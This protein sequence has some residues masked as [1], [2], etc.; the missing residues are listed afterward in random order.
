MN[1]KE[2]MRISELARITGVSTQTIHYYLR[3]GLLLPPTKTAPNMA[4][5]GSEHVEDIKLIKQLQEKRYLP[6][7]VIKLVL[8]AKREGKDVS[9]LRDMRLIMEEIFLPLGP[10]ERL[11]PV[12][13]ME[14]VVITG[15][16]AATLE[17]LEEPGLLT[18][19][20][21]PEGKRYNGLDVRIARAVKELLDLGLEPSDLG[22]YR[23]YLE[24][25][26]AEAMVIHDKVFHGSGDK[27][28]IPRMEIKGILD[29]LKTSLV[30]KVYRQ[31]A[32]D[33]Q[34]KEDTDG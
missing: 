28:R 16:S 34:H 1:K 27:K 21:A 14:L 32:T 11:Q 18:P 23:Q 22:F 25:L 33:H 5:Y 9:D 3:E 19:A 7:S 31:A 15:L 4:Y 10:E 2:L 13:L 26:R 17:A 12:T 6:L 29:D 8:Q 20:A 24:A 30:A